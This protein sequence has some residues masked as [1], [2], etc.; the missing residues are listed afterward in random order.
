MQLFRNRKNSF[1]WRPEKAIFRKPKFIALSW[2][3]EKVGFR[4]LKKSLFD[5][6]L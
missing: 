4:K 3:H 6:A 5:G 1:S 2:R